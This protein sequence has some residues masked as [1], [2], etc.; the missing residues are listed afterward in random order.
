MAPDIKQL[1]DAV[2][3]HVAAELLASMQEV[4]AAEQRNDRLT[5]IEIDPHQPVTPAKIDEIA[6]LF[7]P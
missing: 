5:V 1:I 4:E 2:G 7:K 6:T 3:E